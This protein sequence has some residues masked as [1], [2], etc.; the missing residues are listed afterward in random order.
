MCHMGPGCLGTVWGSHLP[1]RGSLSF[2]PEQDLKSRVAHLPPFS[3][4]FVLPYTCQS[5]HVVRWQNPWPHR[6]HLGQSSVWVK[7]ST[8]C[9]ALPVGRAPGLNW[10][11]ARHLSGAWPWPGSFPHRGTGTWWW[12]H[13]SSWAPGAFSRTRCE[14]VLCGSELSLRGRL[15]GRLASGL[16]FPRASWPPATL[17]SPSAPREASQSGS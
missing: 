6:F 10:S 3:V 5:D 2:E 14:R 12:L 9:G 8:W 7:V 4:P 16:R 15:L 1:L 17:P 13:P 11:L